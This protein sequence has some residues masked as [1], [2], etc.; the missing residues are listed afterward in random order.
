MASW[1]SLGAGE[2]SL[3]FRCWHGQASVFGH[4][5]PCPVAL[6]NSGRQV[7]RKSWECLQT[8]VLSETSG[9]SSFS[10]RFLSCCTCCGMWRLHNWVQNCWV[11]YSGCAWAKQT[12]GKK[13][14]KDFILR[15]R[16]SLQC[17]G[18]A[19]KPCWVGIGRIF[20]PIT[21][22]LEQSEEW[23]SKTIQGCK[24]IQFKLGIWRFSQET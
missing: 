1:L 23:S 10:P 15:C 20:L 16:E 4:L 3:L 11:G 21:P 24:T 8:K 12:I 17:S 6:A 13:N 7:W 22:S 9:P 2:R 19:W 18:G 5:L 14:D